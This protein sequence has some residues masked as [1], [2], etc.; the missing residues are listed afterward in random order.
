VDPGPLVSDEC[1]RWFS[2]T[3]Q[4]PSLDRAH[5]M[6]L[7]EEN[8]MMTAP[9]EQLLFGG[10][11]FNPSALRCQ[12]RQG[13]KHCSGSSAVTYACVEIAP[14]IDF[15][16]DYCRWGG[17]CAGFLLKKSFSFTWAGGGRRPGETRLECDKPV[18]LLVCV[19][20]LGLF[21]SSQSA[22]F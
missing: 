12:A 14:Q 16:P 18:L 7:R 13:Q 6:L 2:N 19:N 17:F 8:E 21:P 9:P 20:E 22:R 10:R 15:P 5:P 11:I 4:F 1:R 3:K